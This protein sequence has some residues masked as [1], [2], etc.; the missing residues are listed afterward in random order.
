MFFSRFII[1]GSD[2]TSLSFS[3]DN[4]FTHIAWFFSEAETLVYRTKNGGVWQSLNACKLHC[5]ALR[6][7]PKFFAKTGPTRSDS[8]VGP[9][10][11]QIACISSSTPRVRPSCSSNIQWLSIAIAYKK[12]GGQYLLA[13][14]SVRVASMHWYAGALLHTI[15]QTIPRIYRLWTVCVCLH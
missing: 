14:S 12:D 8:A 2:A 5:Y 1:G 7:A 11:E 6:R 3:L 10:S 13:S 4:F 15:L 9:H